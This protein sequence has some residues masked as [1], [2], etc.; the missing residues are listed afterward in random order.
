M[1]YIKNILMG[2]VLGVSNV[3]PG[4]SAGTMAVILNIYDRLLDVISLD[5]KKIKKNIG[6]IMTI[7]IGAV[8]GILLF[9]NA[10]QFL[11]EKYNMPTNFAFI[12][13]IIGSIPMIVSRAK[14]K[15]GIES[16][17]WI[18]CL[19]TFILML[20]MTIKEQGQ[21]T[22]GV[23]L[24]L[25]LV[26]TMWLMITGAI[27]AFA[28][29]I[30]G[31]SGSFIMLTFGTYDTVIGA[32]AELSTNPFSQQ[33]IGVVVPV[34]VGVLIG[35]GL[36]V[37]LVKIL[38]EKYNQATYMAILGLVVGSVFVIYPGF[39]FNPMGIIS[40]GL[41]LLGMAVAYMFSEK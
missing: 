6:F 28:M 2:M 18:P 35:L 12:G 38:L 11:F 31:I 10:I 34:G 5:A 40:L 33:V 17:N 21:S 37:K 13:I 24:S 23:V 4:V 16:K 8:V 3:I 32:I 29:I 22:E 19:M 25:N 7:G 26:T 41:L 36:G 39:T 27:S 30:P 20:I 9:S 15:R 14:E 1:N